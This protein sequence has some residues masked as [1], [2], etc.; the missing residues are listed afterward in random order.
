MEVELSTEVIH[1]KY[2]SLSIVKVLLK[3]MFDTIDTIKIMVACLKSYIITFTFLC[4]CAFM[5]VCVLAIGSLNKRTTVMKLF[6]VIQWVQWKF[7]D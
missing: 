6:Q 2:C 3:T 1:N 4:L 5:S 7:G